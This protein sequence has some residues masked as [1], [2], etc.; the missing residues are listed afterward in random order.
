MQHPPLLRIFQISEDIEDI[1]IS[2]DPTGSSHADFDEVAAGYLPRGNRRF[3]ADKGNF[4][5]DVEFLKDNIKDPV[6]SF[7]VMNL[8]L[9]SI[10]L[11]EKR[12]RTN[13]DF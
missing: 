5:F 12:E 1:P 9:N 10:N 3:D 4:T 8:S 13:S 11:R 2:I 7:T 6:F